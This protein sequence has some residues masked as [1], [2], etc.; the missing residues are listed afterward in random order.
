M[1]APREEGLQR[2]AFEAGRREAGSPGFHHDRAVAVRAVSAAI[3]G[4]VWPH[5]P[6]VSWRAWKIIIPRTSNGKLSSPLGPLP[7]VRQGLVLGAEPELAP[8]GLD[9]HVVVVHLAGEV[10]D[11]VAGL[12]V[13][14]SLDLA[15]GGGGGAALG[16]AGDPGLFGAGRGGGVGAEL[17][18]VPD[19]VWLDLNEVFEVSPAAVSG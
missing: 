5:A 16:T 11:P 8:L 6:A 14:V 13:D 3:G 2:G 7:A 18:V 12:E 1:K 17:A 10:V 9:G 4:G 15:A 19:P